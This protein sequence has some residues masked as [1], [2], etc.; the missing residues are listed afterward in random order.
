MRF[1]RSLFLARL[2]R[3]S[4]IGVMLEKGDFHYDPVQTSDPEQILQHEP[5]NDPHEL[6]RAEDTIF[7]LQ[8][9]RVSKY[10]AFDPRMQLPE[11]GFIFADRS[12]PQRWCRTRVQRRANRL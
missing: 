3:E 11:P 7:R 4:P 12:N 2:S 6:Q 1:L 8:D 10:S 5:L 9:Q